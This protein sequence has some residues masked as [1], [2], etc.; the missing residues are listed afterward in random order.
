MGNVFFVRLWKA[1]VEQRSWKEN[2]WN[3]EK[4]LVFFLLWTKADPEV[5]FIALFNALCDV[6]KLHS[7]CMYSILNTYNK[8]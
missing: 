7:L 6:C 4:I 3:L 5:G 2:Q 8:M 1:E